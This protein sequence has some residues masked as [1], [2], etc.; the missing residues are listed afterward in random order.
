MESKIP[1]PT[2]NIYNIYKFYA[3]FLLLLFITSGLAV[4]WNSNTTNETVQSLLKEYEELMT[5]IGF[6]PF[7]GPTYALLSN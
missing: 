6:L 4:V 2:Y 3:L 5:Q 7:I 1:L